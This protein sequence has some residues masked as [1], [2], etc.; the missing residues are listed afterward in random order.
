VKRCTAGEALGGLSQG[1]VLEKRLVVYRRVKCPDGLL[2]WLLLGTCM[3]R[4]MA[5]E[6]SHPL[7]L[8]LEQS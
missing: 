2:E 3:L 5:V 8:F 1:K 7:E 4:A 6:M